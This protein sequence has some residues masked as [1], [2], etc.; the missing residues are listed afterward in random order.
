MSEPKRRPLFYGWVIVAISTLALLVSNGL[1]IGGIPVFYKPIQEDF[2]SLGTVTTQTADR[3]TGDAASLTFLLAGI[4]SLVVGSLIQRFSLK[5]L[6]VAGCFFLG[7]GLIFYSRATM[8]WQVYVSHSLLGLSLGLVGVMI[9]TVLI[10]NWFLR[11][12]GTAMGILL[13]GTS[14]GGVLIPLIARPL[15]ASYGWRPAIFILSLAVWLIL[16]PAIIFFVKDRASDIGE[17]FDGVREK[18][19][20][21]NENISGGG[22]TLG[23]AMRTANFWIL[24]LCAAALF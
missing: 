7:G 10:A 15:I 19:E 17:N 6:M 12:R 11:R 8:P 2:L 23:E 3:V 13:T 4:F 20:T 21:A 9:Q 5:S 18:I 24:S 16:L 22:L 14:F 1:S